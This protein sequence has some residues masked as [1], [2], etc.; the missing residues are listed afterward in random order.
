[1]TEALTRQPNETPVVSVGR[2][3]VYNEEIYEE[4]LKS[5]DVESGDVSRVEV[6]EDGDGVL[7]GEDEESDIGLSSIAYK[8]RGK[9]TSAQ[10]GDQTIEKTWSALMSDCRC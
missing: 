6:V 7:K 9:G 1:M 5:V 2:G 4:L 8:L 3:W 10:V